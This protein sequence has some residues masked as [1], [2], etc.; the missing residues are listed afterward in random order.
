MASFDWGKGSVLATSQ[1]LVAVGP[2]SKWNGSTILRGHV[3]DMMAA[4]ES[5][6]NA[7]AREATRVELGFAAADDWLA[8]KLAD[9]VLFKQ[10][11]L[12][13]SAE[14]YQELMRLMS[15]DGCK[16]AQVGTCD[17]GDDSGLVKD[18]TWGEALLLA[19]SPEGSIMSDVVEA[20]AADDKAGEGEGFAAKLHGIEGPMVMRPAIGTTE[21]RRLFEGLEGKGQDDLDTVLGDKGKGRLPSRWAGELDGVD[22]SNDEMDVGDVESSPMT[23]AGENRV[24]RGR[25]L[26]RIAALEET[27]DRVEGMVK[28]LVAL[29]G[30]ASPTEWLEVEKRKG[31]MAREW[32]ISIAKAGEQ[33]KAAAV[34]KAANKRVRRRELDDVRAEEA[35]LRQE[36]VVKTKEAART[37]AEAERDRRVTEVRG[38]AGGPEAVA[39]AEKVVEAAR[40]V[41]E[42]EREVAACAAP[43]EIGGW[44]VVGGKKRKTVQVVSRL[45]RPLDG[46]GRKSLQSAVSKVQGLVGAASLGW[47]LVASPYTVHG[48]DEVLWTVRGVGEEVEGTEVTGTILK[49]LE[50]VWGVGSLVGC[51]IENKMSAYVVVSGIPEREWLS[52]QGGV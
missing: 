14:E 40:M 26:A 51:W 2:A 13:E 18:S 20:P 8:A 25:C 41:V 23:G 45:S 3:Q 49:N 44:Q 22:F 37:A 52:A 35:R 39:V 15:E 38:C 48:G 46:E 5:A 29:G 11:L 30:L 47:G 10:V 31:R 12:A 4:A 28:L 34:V 17:W 7:Q 1:Y 19:Y 21:G 50:A 36:E 6:L 32:D 33:A 9:P 27:L 16:W 24:C 43:V 42:L